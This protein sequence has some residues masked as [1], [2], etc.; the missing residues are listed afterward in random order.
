MGIIAKVLDNLAD[1]SYGKHAPSIEAKNY[2][3]TLI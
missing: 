1:N 3:H 2:T